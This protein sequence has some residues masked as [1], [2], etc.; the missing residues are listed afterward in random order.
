MS[1]RRVA[2]K[3]NVSWGCWWVRMPVPS[4]I[5]FSPATTTKTD[6]LCLDEVYTSAVGQ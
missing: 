1:D 2:R 4:P 5:P 6:F 3:L